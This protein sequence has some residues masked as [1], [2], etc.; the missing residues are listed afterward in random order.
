MIF[1][2]NSLHKNTLLNSAARK[3]KEKLEVEVPEYKSL[4]EKERERYAQSEVA[5]FLFLHEV[6][7]AQSMGLARNANPAWRFGERNTLSERLYSESYADAYAGSHYQLFFS[8]KPNFTNQSNF[9]SVLTYA[10]VRSWSEARNND[11]RDSIEQHS[12]QANTKDFIDPRLYGHS[13]EDSAVIGYRAFLASPNDEDARLASVK[14]IAYGNAYGM[15]K[16]VVSSG[17]LGKIDEVGEEKDLIKVNSQ[18][19]LCEQT[20]LDLDKLKARRQMYS[21]VESRKLDARLSK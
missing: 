15:I 7:H 19:D 18:A 9:S 16:N 20:G 2:G 13:T 5:K 11:H 12:K 10:L 3:L 8:T 14:A 17:K 4:N 6:G 1:I 21:C